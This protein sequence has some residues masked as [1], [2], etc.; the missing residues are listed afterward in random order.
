MENLVLSDLVTIVHSELVKPVIYA[1]D[2]P[3]YRRPDI[4]FRVLEDEQLRNLE[5]G[6]DKRILE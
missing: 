4:L 5:N 3:D 6:D 2:I 1:E